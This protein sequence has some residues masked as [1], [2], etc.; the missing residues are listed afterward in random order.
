M[1]IN[2]PFELAA[3]VG[4]EPGRSR[5][6]FAVCG[7]VALATWG[8]IRATK[9]A[10][11]ATLDTDAAAAQREVR[12]L[13]LESQVAFEAMRF[14]GLDITR[15]TVWDPRRSGPMNVIDWIRP[16]SIRYART[17]LRRSV[18]VRLG[19]QVARFLSPEDF[20]LF[21]VLSTRDL[22]VED[23]ASVLV[24]NRGRINLRRISSGVGSLARAITDHDVAGRWK[25]VL[26]RA[27]SDLDIGG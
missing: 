15:T 11:I 3:A 21:K 19:S 13:G 5:N 18:L 4:G 10:D 14:G 16:R 20:I 7:G 9:D 12:R 17:A 22:D 23:A 25:A 26:L 6:P 24:R 2:D 27:E 8:R 1:D